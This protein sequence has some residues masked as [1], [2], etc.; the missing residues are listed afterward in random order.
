MGLD[1]FEARSVHCGHSRA[2]MLFR[3]SVE[4]DFNWDRSYT[5][6]KVEKTEFVDTHPISYVFSI[7]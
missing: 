4:K 1:G 6:F 3:K 5:R 2:V 7:S